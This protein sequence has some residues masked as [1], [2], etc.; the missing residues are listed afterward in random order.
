MYSK[1]S[2]FVLGFHGCDKSVCEKIISGKD[3]LQN[4]TNE[5]DWLGH[6]LY[7]WENDPDRALKY[8]K[9]L[10]EHPGRAKVPINDP[11]VLGAIIDLGR[12]LN[13]IEYKSLD[14]LKGAY[15][16]FKM[17]QEKLGLPLPVQKELNKEKIF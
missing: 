13:L 6:G 7:F 11:Y 10:K 8:A 5:Y 15:E 1:P 4:S 12:C 9:L 16:I 3:T 14:I 17:S 2:A